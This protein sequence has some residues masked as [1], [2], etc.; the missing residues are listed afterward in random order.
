MLLLWSMAL[1]A[2]CTM[3]DGVWLLTMEPGDDAQTI[4][5]HTA[6]L[7][8]DPEQAGYSPVYDYGR[9]AVESLPK[10]AWDVLNMQKPYYMGSRS[11]DDTVA[12]YDRLG[13]GITAQ[14]LAL[15]PSQRDAVAQRL[16]AD[17]GAGG[18]FDYNWYRPNCTTRVQDLLDDVLDGALRDAWSTPGT[19]PADEVLRHSGPNLPLWLGLRWGSGRF[20][21]T[22]VSR[23]DAAFLP[24]GLAAELADLR[25]DGRPLVTEQCTLGG[26]EPRPVPPR[27]PRRWLPLGLVGL[28]VGGGTAGLGTARPAWARALVAGQALVLG[29]WGCAALLVGT[30]GTFA[31]FWGHHNLTLASPLTL[32][33]LPAAA[34][35][36]RRPGSRA[37]AGIAIALLALALLGTAWS[38]V[39]GDAD[40]NLGL[41]LALLPVLGAA[42]WVLR[43]HPPVDAVP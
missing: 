33:L 35:H 38:L 43:P 19:S 31:P 42:V 14:K 13:R 1:A 25:L 22:A 6:V 37:P 10:M 27:G 24:D 8:Y 32:L 30:L 36:R 5:G 20:A 18:T 2:P 7:D 26:V 12:R 23:Y 34:L 21:H 41:G 29:L 16:A 4:F 11:L 28:V 3:S 40:R 9:F 15:T 17:L 39:A